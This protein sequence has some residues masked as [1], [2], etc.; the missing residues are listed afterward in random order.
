MSNLLDSLI[1]AFFEAYLEAEKA[2]QEDPKKLNFPDAIDV[3]YRV[4][5]DGKH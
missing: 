3:E 1:S 2:H 5:D 4:I